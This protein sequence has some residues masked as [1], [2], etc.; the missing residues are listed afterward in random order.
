VSKP[1]VL[2]WGGKSQA[3]IL[4]E[5]ILELELG[6]PRIIFDYSLN[7]PEFSSNATGIRTL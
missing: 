1:G 5:M 2:I 6:I 7:F 3:H 4:H